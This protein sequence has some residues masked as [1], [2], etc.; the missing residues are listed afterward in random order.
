MREK[1]DGTYLHA[2]AL[3]AFAL[4]VLMPGL[5][6]LCAAAMLKL[7]PFGGNVQTDPDLIHQYFP[8]AAE[9][10]RKLAGGE[11][12]FFSFCGG[13]GYNLW[14]TVAY[15]AASPLNLLLAL[16]PESG[17][18]DFV[19]A[20]ILFKCALC[21]GTLAWYLVRSEGAGCPIAVSFGTLFALSNY[22][23]GYKFNVMWLDSIAV[24]PLIM[25][26]IECI[27]RGKRGGVYLFSLFYALWCNFY[28]GY[29]LCLFAC[30]YFLLVLFLEQGQDLQ[31][32]LRRAGRFA[33]C[34]LAGGGMTSTLLLPAWFALR[35]TGSSVSRH[36]PSEW[37]YNKDLSFLLAHY[38]DRG[39]IL[40][41]YDR[42]QVHLY[43]GVIVLLLF[44]LYLANRGI[45]RRER[46]AFGG[47]I[48]FFLLCFSVAPLNYVW[49]GF[50]LVQGLPNRFAFLYLVVLL[51]LCCRSLLRLDAVTPRGFC[52][53]VGSVLALTA[54]LCLQ[55]ML[56]GQDGSL[57][58]SLGLLTLY[59]LLLGLK[60]AGLGP[61]RRV[62]LLLCVLMI[63][64][65]AGHALKDFREQGSSGEAFYTAYQRDFQT[66]MRR[67]GE[68][69]FFRSEIDSRS[70]LNFPA[71]AGANGIALYSSAISDSLCRFMSSLN[72]S[73]GNNMVL[74]RGVPKPV[75]DL[76]GVKY[77]VSGNVSAATW[78]GLKKANALGRKN[79]YRNGEALSLGYL[80]SERILDWRPGG[81]GMKSLNDLALLCAGVE[82]LYSPGERFT[83][84]SGE[85]CF[86]DIP[87]GGELCVALDGA[88]EEVKWTT[89]EYSRQFDRRGDQLSSTRLLLPASSPA[90]PGR[91]ELQVTT[92]GAPIYTGTVYIRSEEGYRRLTEALSAHQ[93]Q[94]VRALGTTL[95]GE[96]SAD[97]SD[98]L[99]LTL[100]Y[101]RGW[102]VELD[103]RKAE[104]LE[105][106][107]ALTGV[108]VGPGEHRL[109]MYY[110]PQ[111]FDAGVLLT[112]AAAALAFLLLRR[113]KRCRRDPESR[114]E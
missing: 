3:R 110:V 65:S 100:L 28:I 72:V 79:L 105:I 71:Y 89:P 106:G 45:R 21:G 43:C 94:N 22:L 42:G 84:K 5:V 52:L 60:R 34:S 56:R 39:S 92:G 59:A 61:E 35:A 54:G 87:E 19:M 16:V 14:A 55:R 49:H 93:L 91:A 50:H 57:V 76:L 96:I 25:Y 73:K 53:A 37:L 70:M 6:F 9:L 48:L 98:I 27:V 23:L 58:I 77:V 107:G 80:V 78:N 81:E 97:R 29:M 104:P 63:A 36:G 82:E 108:A 68:K 47:L 66:L 102:R 99:L 13:L 31:T 4:G 113:D 95:T 69:S 90:A 85:A 67:T 114:T 88:P 17:V 30:L 1:T 62:S 32:R 64:E 10:R 111:G 2:R 38:E 75:L 40:T 44:A 101:D 112:A 74:Y 51:K 11:L 12:P 109:R 86:F 33:L 46:F 18:C 15:Y 103:G 41:S 24:T 26:G 8:F 20:M 7:W 83:G